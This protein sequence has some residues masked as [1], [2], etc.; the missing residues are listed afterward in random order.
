MGCRAG[1]DPPAVQRPSTHCTMRWHLEVAVADLEEQLA[2]LCAHPDLGA[3][4]RMSDA[5]TAEQAGAGLDSLT[6]TEFER[7]SG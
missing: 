2:L 5:S 6:R 4:A 1:V 3:R 7:L